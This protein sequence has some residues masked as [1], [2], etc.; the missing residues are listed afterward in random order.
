[1]K[2]IGKQVL[3]LTTNETDLRN[4]ES[5]MIRLKNGRI[6]H[7]YTEFYG[8]DRSDHAPSRIS[9]VFSDDEGES[10]SLQTRDGFLVSYYYSNGG[11]ICRNATK[12]AKIYTEEL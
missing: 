2:K 9:A 6:M 10:F 3:L 4:G 7:A 8:A 11:H 1:M 12:I 5:A